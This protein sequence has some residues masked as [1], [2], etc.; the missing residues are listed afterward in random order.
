LINIGLIGFVVQQF[1]LKELPIQGLWILSIA[2]GVGCFG[3]YC[4]DIYR[5]RVRKGLDN[6]MK[7]TSYSLIILFVP[8]LLIFILNIPFKIEEKDFLQLVLAYGFS[9]FFGFITAIILGQ[10]FKTLPF[11]VWMHR[12]QK[13]VGKQKTPLPKDLFSERFLHWQNIS[14]FAGFVLLVTGLIISN[15]ALI[16]TGS[17]FMVLTGLFYLNNVFKILTHLIEPKRIVYGREGENLRVAER[18]Y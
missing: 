17:L 5:K 2:A 8:V 14:Y 1:F 10:T 7:Q 4:A 3:W 16:Q 11:I 13:L 9:I 6:A 12:Y 15:T 18:D